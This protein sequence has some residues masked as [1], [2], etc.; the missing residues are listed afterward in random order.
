MNNNFQGERWQM[1][2]MKTAE[3]YSRQ[4]KGKQHGSV[5]DLNECQWPKSE[6]RACDKAVGGA[7]IDL[8]LLLEKNAKPLKCLVLILYSY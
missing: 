1:G 7:I 5:D 8:D 4:G 6:R 3:S 2:R